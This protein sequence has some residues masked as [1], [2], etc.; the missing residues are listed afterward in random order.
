MCRG[1]YT[2]V[3]TMNDLRVLIIADDPLTRAG[4]AALLANQMGYIVVSQIAGEGDV[5]AQLDVFR[6]D[7][8]V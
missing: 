4:L 3:L 7:V 8:V 5:S 6:P 2:I 1:P